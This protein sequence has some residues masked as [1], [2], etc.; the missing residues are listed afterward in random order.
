MKPTPVKEFAEWVG[1]EAVGFDP[2]V[3][4]ST[5]A[6]DSNAIQAG[7]LFLAIKGSKFDG[8]DFVPQALS[9]GAV[10]TLAERHVPGPHIL[11]ENLVQAL[12]KLA[13]HF[14]SGFEGPVVG[15]TGS[16]GKT[17][18]KEFVASAL[19]PLGPILKNPG[20]RN[21]EYT[22][23]LLWTDLQPGH[24]AVVVEMAMRGFGQIAHLASF[25]KPTVGL[26]TNI[27]YAHMEM[28]ESR[29]GIT[30]AKG[31]LL[32]V[33]PSYG[34][35]VLWFEDDM[36]EWLRIWAASE[37][38]TFGYEDGA[39][40]RITEYQAIDWHSA[41]VAGSCNGMRW[42]TKMPAVGRHIALNVAAAVLVAAVLGIDPERAAAQIE[43][44]VLPPMRMEVVERD[45]ATILLD[46]YNASPP[47]MIAAI[48][49]LADLP[50][51]GR[52]LAVI[53]E[54]RELGQY[55]E[56]AHRSVGAALGEAGFDRVLFYGPATALAAEEAIQNGMSPS[57]ILMASS[58]EDVEQFLNQMQPGDA[59]LI[60]GSRA[61]ELERALK[62][63]P[64]S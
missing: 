48:Q 26:V 62:L 20:N 17:T 51:Q 47:S 16:A 23:P 21:S 27:G 2:T 63:E 54:M 30:M 6:L 28:V 1:G 15:V 35:A 45:G 61:L 25:S 42:E 11:V 7:D 9:S 19:S 44:S 56:N 55:T 46:T 31:E 12:A 52:R 24:Q 34:A 38:L 33:L 22:S 37:V 57:A 41:I 18:T 59:A 4:I 29:F 39:D 50:A 64:H 43:H 8:H 60:K 58:I 13:T 32:D 49:T 5:F 3:V 40:C 10:G 53:G 14:R 36:L